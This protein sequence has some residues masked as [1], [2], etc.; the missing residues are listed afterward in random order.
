MEKAVVAAHS[1]IAESTLVVFDL[2]LGDRPKTPSTGPDVSCN[3]LDTEGLWRAQSRLDLQTENL[4]DIGGRQLASVSTRCHRLGQRYW[5]RMAFFQLPVGGLEYLAGRSPEAQEEFKGLIDR[6]LPRET[7]GRV[8]PLSYQAAAYVFLLEPSESWEPSRAIG[9]H[10]P[11]LWAHLGLHSMAPV[12]AGLADLVLLPAPVLGTAPTGFVAVWRAPS[13][14]GPALLTLPHSLLDLVEY[15]LSIELVRDLT[16]RLEAL[17]LAP[18]RSADWFPSRAIENLRQL[19]AY[20]KRHLSERQLVLSELLADGED[21]RAVDQRIRSNIVTCFEGQILDV[22]SNLV[23]NPHKFSMI[24]SLH[25][26]RPAA[27]E[28]HQQARLGV[29][30]TAELMSDYVRD[31]ANTE[32]ALSNLALQRTMR[33]LTVVGVLAGIAAV[34]VSVLPDEAQNAAWYAL[35]VLFFR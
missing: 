25:R 30:D 18:K 19:Q 33:R 32:V 13:R 6:F 22:A 26:T 3:W 1:G 34:A 9:E 2:V 15:V 12:P 14:V 10:L 23:T 20:L 31:V 17:P 27:W 28:A 24:G 5:L 35:K 29:E 7:L 8:W 21:F 16:T 11:R 4:P